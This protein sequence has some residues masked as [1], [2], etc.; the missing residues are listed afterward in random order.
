MMKQKSNVSASGSV[1]AKEAMAILNP[2]SWEGLDRKCPASR[3]KSARSPGIALLPDCRFRASGYPVRR[4]TDTQ[5]QICEAV[6]VSQAMVNCFEV[7][8]TRCWQQNICSI[9]KFSSRFFVAGPL[10]S[11]QFFGPKR[12]NRPASLS[13]PEACGTH[14]V[15]P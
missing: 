5:L 14:Q 3:L 15:T 13:L 10:W 7:N 8:H 11:F 2:L 4:R 12:W 1:A 9:C 6:S